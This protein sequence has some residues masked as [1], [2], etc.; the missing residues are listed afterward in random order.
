MPMFG[1]GPSQATL[2]VGLSLLDAQVPF[3]VAGSLSNFTVRASGLNIG[4]GGTFTYS[5]LINGVATLSCGIPTVPLLSLGVD[6]CAS[7]GPVAV[8]A[9]DTI[10]VQVSLNGLL[11]LSAGWATWSALFSP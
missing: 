4:L 5:V 11:S 8:N 10:I 9:G 6:T 3:P 1:L 7:A 2:L